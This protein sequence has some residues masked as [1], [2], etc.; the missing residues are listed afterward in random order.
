MIFPADWA[1][2]F[3]DAPTPG[4]RVEG[5]AV[6]GDGTADKATAVPLAATFFVVA[7]VEAR[8][9]FPEGEPVAAALIRT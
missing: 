3:D 9:T 5:V 7:P 8:V 6:T 4:H 1:F 2:R